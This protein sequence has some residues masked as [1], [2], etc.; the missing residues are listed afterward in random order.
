MSVYGSYKTSVS[1]NLKNPE[2]FYGMSKNIG[3]EYGN[4]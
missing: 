1:E 3:E 4:F 2:S